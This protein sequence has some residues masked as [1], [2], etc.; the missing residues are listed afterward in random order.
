MQY[1]QAA[2]G[3]HLFPKD[4]DDVENSPGTWKAW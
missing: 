3:F 1:S 2:P 4:E